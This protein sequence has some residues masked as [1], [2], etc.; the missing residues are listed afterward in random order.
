MLQRR[1]ICPI[2]RV[3]VVEMFVCRLLRPYP[4]PAFPSSQRFEI[5]IDKARRF[6]PFFWKCWCSVTVKIGWN[7]FNGKVMELERLGAD[8]LL[9]LRNSLIRTSIASLPLKKKINPW[10][11]FTMAPLID[12]Q[13]SRSYYG[14]IRRRWLVSVVDFDGNVDWRSASISLKF[15]EDIK[16]FW[17]EF[18]WRLKQFFWRFADEVRWCLPDPPQFWRL[19]QSFD[20]PG[21]SFHFCRLL[22]ES[23]GSAVADHRR[24][25]S[26][27][28]VD[29]SSWSGFCAIFPGRSD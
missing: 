27:Q 13:L 15:V 14:F 8:K 29:S 11:M 4:P 12:F 20:P 26:F 9:L 5:N 23:F 6:E 19:I 24:I 16:I 22:I 28:R 17:D 18:F 7:E 3:K 1:D 2:N 10:G 25:G 21:L